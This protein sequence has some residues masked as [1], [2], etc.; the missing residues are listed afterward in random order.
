MAANLPFWRQLSSNDQ[1]MA[2]LLASMSYHTRR[3]KLGEELREELRERCSEEFIM[4]VIELRQAADRREVS[5]RG[6]PLRLVEL[7]N[8]AGAPPRQLWPVT[9]ARS[10]I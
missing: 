8:P 7:G 10:D 2:L 6:R 1:M 5:I 4:A 9:E 3:A